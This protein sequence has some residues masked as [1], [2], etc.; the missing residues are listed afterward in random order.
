MEREE[1]ILK[2]IEVSGGY[3]QGEIAEFNTQHV[4][5][6]A[7]QFHTAEQNVILQETAMMLERYYISRTAAKEHLQG[8][9]RTMRS[10]NA[11]GCSTYDVNFLR[12]QGEGKSQHDILRIA[13]EILQEDR[14]LSTTDCGG[15]NVYFY[16]DDCLYTGNKTKYDILKSEQLIE[17]PDGFTLVSYHFSIF[18][19]G[20][21]Y[22]VGAIES[23]LTR[24]NSRLKP[25]RK[26]W[27]NNA[28]FGNENLD[29]FFPDYV[30][31]NAQI[32]AFIN[33]SNYLCD[34]KGWS[35]KQMFRTSTASSNLFSTPQNKQI[36]EQAFLA[37]GARMFCAAANPAPSMRPMGFEVLAT[38][39][40]GNPVITWRNIANNC[41]L[42][43]WYGDP[44]YGPNH[45]L[46]IWYPL[47]PRKIT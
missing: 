12:T 9:F 33:H 2:I 15:S 19:Q 37:A 41:P 5:R 28:R 35:R 40:F 39:G 22:A 10:E 24:R 42:A 26:F 31:G 27:Y 34:E 3:R 44:A 25:F 30:A 29:I 23:A 46:G 47:F 6:W 1:S 45:P 17:A 43:L 4:E 14:G 20:F 38:I 16:I 32:D 8:M 13:D 11:G 21:Q 18:N 36:V 7:D